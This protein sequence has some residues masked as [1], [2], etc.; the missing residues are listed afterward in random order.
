MDI[1]F[2]KLENHTQSVR[3]DTHAHYKEVLEVLEKTQS[4]VFGYNSL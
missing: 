4:K 3:K 2:T 1:N